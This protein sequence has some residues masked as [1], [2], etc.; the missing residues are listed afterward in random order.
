MKNN[1]FLEFL[2]KLLEL[3]YKPEGGYSTSRFFNTGF[4]NLEIEKGRTTDKKE[5]NFEVKPLAGELPLTAFVVIDKLC[6]EYDVLC[7]YNSKRFYFKTTVGLY[8][9]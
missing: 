2:F 3:S 9:S 5:I 1:K 4:I 6:K 8:S 7:S